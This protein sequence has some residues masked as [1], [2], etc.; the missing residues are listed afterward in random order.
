MPSSESSCGVNTS[1][2]SFFVVIDWCRPSIGLFLK[3]EVIINQT[4]NRGAVPAAFGGIAK[5]KDRANQI[6]NNHSIRMYAVAEIG[7]LSIGKK[8]CP[9]GG[10]ERVGDLPNSTRRSVLA[11]ARGHRWLAM[12]ESG[13]ATSMKE[14]AR[15]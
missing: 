8:N 9:S 6:V 1:C 11:L 2:C 15:R 4:G 12:L 10:G 14:I 7:D 3:G 5:D 13:E